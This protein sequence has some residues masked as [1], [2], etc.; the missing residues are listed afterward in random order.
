MPFTRNHDILK[1]RD[2]F[3]LET[4][5]FS[6]LKNRFMKAEADTMMYPFMTLNDNTGI[7]ESTAY[8]IMEFSQKEELA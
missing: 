7:I 8:L 1:S 2:D 4:A 5:Y 6:V 3:L